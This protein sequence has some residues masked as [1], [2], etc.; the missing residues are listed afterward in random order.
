MSQQRCRKSRQPLCCPLPWRKPW[1]PRAWQAKWCWLW[2]ATRVRRH[3]YRNEVPSRPSW[4]AC[5]QSSEPILAMTSPR[6]WWRCHDKRQK[7]IGV[8]NNCRVAQDIVSFQ[9]PRRPSKSKA[10]RQPDARAREC[11]RLCHD[12]CYPRWLSCPGWCWWW[13]HPDEWWCRYMK[14]FACRVPSSL[15]WW[16]CRAGISLQ[17]LCLQSEHDGLWQPSCRTKTCQVQ[18]LPQAT[19]CCTHDIPHCHDH[20]TTQHPWQILAWR[21]R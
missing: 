10:K 6:R 3:A 20:Y 7:D 13:K 11:H 9:A 4:H 17:A 2:D 5:P 18:S 12:H 16:A 19:A 8:W 21:K 15:C 14:S 1:C